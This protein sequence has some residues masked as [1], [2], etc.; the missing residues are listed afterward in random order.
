MAGYA[1]VRSVCWQWRSVAIAIAAAHTPRHAVPDAS[2]GGS[3]GGGGG[4]SLE[5]LL[6]PTAASGSGAAPS[7]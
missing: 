3:D 2:D 1:T 4:N 5:Q 7:Q 6:E